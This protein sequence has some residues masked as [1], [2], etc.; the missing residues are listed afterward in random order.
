MRDAYIVTSVRTPGCRRAKGAFVDKCA[1][2]ENPGVLTNLRERLCFA[3]RGAFELLATCHRC[4]RRHQVRADT[5]Q[6]VFNRLVLGEM[7]LVADHGFINK[8]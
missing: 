4:G 1:I 3:A 2:T 6:I 5:R 7:L 8:G